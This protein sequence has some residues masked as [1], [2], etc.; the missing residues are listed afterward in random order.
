M[1]RFRPVAE[2][3]EIFARLK[4]KFGDALVEFV[5]AA[6]PYIVVKSESLRDVCLHLRTEGFGSLLC[7]SGLD[8][9]G[10]KVSTK[11]LPADAPKT[12][13]PEP[14]VEEIA[15]VYHIESMA[16]GE[17]IALRVGLDRTSPRVASVA[18]I[19]KVANW[20]E[21]EAYDMF[22]IIFEGHPNLTRILC[23]DDWQGFPLRKDYVFPTVY[24]EVP[25]ARRV[26]GGEAVERDK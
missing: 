7:L 13:K 3:A 14:S 5:P 10:M 25:H 17:R 11:P 2:P 15:V 22:G 24:G 12:A 26:S 4:E 9:K 20:H 6:T 21:R 19:W 8:T 18:D 23:P 16:S 1:E